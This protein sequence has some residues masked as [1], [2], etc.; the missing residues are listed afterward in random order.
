MLTPLSV[1]WPATTI[2][3]GGSSFTMPFI[4]DSMS[5]IRL[6]STKYDDALQ[7]DTGWERGWERGRKQQH[8]WR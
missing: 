1:L 4:R 2:V 3:G 8:E 5:P 6:L 7:S